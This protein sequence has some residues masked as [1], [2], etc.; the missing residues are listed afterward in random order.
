MVSLTN[1]QII[2]DYTVKCKRYGAK[3]TCVHYLGS[4]IILKIKFPFKNSRTTV[5]K[6]CIL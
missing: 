2:F 4:K 5:C 1:T 3:S 6:N